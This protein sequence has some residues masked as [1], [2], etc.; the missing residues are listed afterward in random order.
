M[1]IPLKTYFPLNLIFLSALMMFG[2]TGCMQAQVD[3]GNK[4]ISYKVNKSEEEWKAILSDEEFYILRE[5]GTERA[6]TGKYWDHKE[7]GIY[8]CAGCA[9]PLF[10]SETKFKSGTGWPSYYEPLADTCVASLPDNSYGWNRVEVVCANCGGHLGH[11]FD[12]GPPPTGLRYCI[13]SASLRFK[14]KL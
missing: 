8:V 2:G 4:I 10:S 3:E 7:T 1:A 13:N 12:D 5:K 11:V 9:H 6:F 14:K